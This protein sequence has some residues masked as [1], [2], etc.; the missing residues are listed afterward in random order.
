MKSFILINAVIYS[1]Q[2]VIP[3]GWVRIEDGSITHVAQGSN[4]PQEYADEYTIDVQG[5]AVLPGFI[6]MHIHGAQGHEVMEGTSEALS[7]LARHCAQYGVTSFLAATITA[8]PG[9]VHQVLRCI[10]KNSGPIS[11]GARLLGAYVEGPYISKDAKGAH[12]ADLISRANP[13][14]YHQWFETGAVK[15]LVVAPEYEEN[16]RLIAE[17]ASRGIIACVGH[18]H[19]TYEKINEAIAQGATQ[20]THTFNAMSGIH[21]RAPGA[22]GAVL[23]HDKV[24][25]EVI[26]DG[27]HLHPALI[28]L[29]VRAKGVHAIILVTDARAGAGLKEG[30]YESGGECCVVTSTAVYLQ[31]GTLAGSILTMNKALLNVM[32]AT[33]LPLQEAWPMSSYTAACQLGIENAKGDIRVGHDADMVIMDP[34]DHTIL[35]TICEG[36]VVYQKSESFLALPS[37]YVFSPYNH[38]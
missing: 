22:A 17:C 20:A 10:A 33:G 29:M 11:G 21:H 24:R 28:D 12:P 34:R 16:M 13:Y 9:R 8:D 1:L 30:I 7:A 31:D 23:L 26:A 37:Q 4:P 14:D 18:T 15:A 25:C 5:N 36:S 2:G 6:D 3:Q 35:M 32:N 27:V 38:Q 19:A